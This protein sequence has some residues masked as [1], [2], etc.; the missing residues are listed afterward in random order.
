MR[1]S[2]CMS[3]NIPVSFSGNNSPKTSVVVEK[4]YRLNSAS[5]HSYSSLANNPSRAKYRLPVIVMRGIN[6]PQPESQDIPPRTGP[7]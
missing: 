4:G 6:Y 2:P 1:A 7:Q 3:D 5:H